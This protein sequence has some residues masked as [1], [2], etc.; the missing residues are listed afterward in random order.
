MTHDMN[1]A[2]LMPPRNSKST[3]AYHLLGIGR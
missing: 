3:L 1:Q 2:A